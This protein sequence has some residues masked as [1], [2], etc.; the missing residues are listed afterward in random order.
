MAASTGVPGYDLSDRVALVTGA[1]SGIGRASAVLLGRAGATVV[2]TDVDASTVAETAAAI[3]RGSAIALDVSDRAAVSAA[4]DS[5]ARAFGH[6]DVMANIAGVMSTGPS[7]DVGEHEIDRVLGINL[8]GVVWGCQ[9][10]GRVMAA[11]GSGSIVNMAS[12][13]VDV[14][15]AELLCYGMAKAGVGQLTKTFAAELGHAGVRVNAVAPGLVVTTTTS[16]HFTRAD[17][18]IDEDRRAAT[19]GGWE[20]MSPMGRVGQPEDIAHAVLY[21]AADASWFVT[22]QILRPNGGSTMPW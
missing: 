4:V 20:R 22:G 14:P 15:G 1:G 19:V 18:S 2:C 17:G 3:P 11:Q 12:G 10:A 7:L 13:V 8:K 9:A 16:R 6:L 5:T 21:L